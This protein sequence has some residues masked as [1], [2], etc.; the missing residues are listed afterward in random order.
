MLSSVK[1]W[2]KSH[3]QIS[4]HQFHRKDEASVGK[5]FW[6]RVPY[7]VARI[8]FNFFLR[9]S[10][11]IITSFLFHCKIKT[12]LNFFLKNGIPYTFYLLPTATLYI[13]QINCHTILC[14]LQYMSHQ[15][16]NRYKKHE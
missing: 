5:M 1:E 15:S 13:C 4:Y 12:I 8:S 2:K 11:F 7:F 14:L 10:N 6:Y 16:L 9:L 3:A